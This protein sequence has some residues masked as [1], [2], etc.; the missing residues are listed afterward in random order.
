MA[1]EQVKPASEYGAVDYN[2]LDR[3]NHR[4]PINNRASSGITHNL[5]DD[6]INWL[7]LSAECLLDRCDL[8]KVGDLVNIGID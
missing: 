6:G 5:R 8:F 1:G 2:L 7:L 4:C 3:Q